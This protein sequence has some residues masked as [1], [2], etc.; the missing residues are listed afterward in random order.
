MNSGAQVN[1]A[2]S[3]SSI[4]LVNLASHNLLKRT[5]TKYYIAWSAQ[6]FRTQRLFYFILLRGLHR[7]S[8]RILY[9]IIIPPFGDIR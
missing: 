9:W 6:V 4:T 3:V 8:A 1:L 7:F 2:M 5:Y